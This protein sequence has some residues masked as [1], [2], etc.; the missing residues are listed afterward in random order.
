[1]IPI[2]SQHFFL[3]NTLAGFTRRARFP[4]WLGWERRSWRTG[5]I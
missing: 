1:M 2:K 5:N 3:N 4:W